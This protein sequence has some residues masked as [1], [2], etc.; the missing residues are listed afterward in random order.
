MLRRQFG[1]VDWRCVEVVLR[2]REW[3]GWTDFFVLVV[4]ALVLVLVFLC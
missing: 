2:V 3:R 4:L 1:V